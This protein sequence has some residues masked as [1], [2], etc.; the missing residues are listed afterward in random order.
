MLKPDLSYVLLYVAQPLESAKFYTQI[1]GV[2]PVESSPTFV[3]Y[4]LPNGIKLGLWDRTT[5][6]PTVTAQP[7]CGEICFAHDDIDGLYN[8]WQKLHIK[9][10][11]PPTDM[12]FG[13]TFVALDP[14]GNRIR[15]FK[16]YEK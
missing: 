9:M 6:E 16:L 11:Q 3:L 8:L 14:D 2:Q 4:V 13:R 1:L 7:G 12:D 15:I 5:V 10:A